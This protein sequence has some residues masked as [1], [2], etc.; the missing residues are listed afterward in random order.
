MTLCYGENLI[1]G[2]AQ[3]AKADNALM[4]FI[5]NV[6][7]KI[8]KADNDSPSIRKGISVFVQETADSKIAFYNTAS[9]KYIEEFK[10]FKDINHMALYAAMF[11]NNGY[12]Q[13]EDSETDADRV[14]VLR[15]GMHFLY[16]KYAN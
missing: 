4:R 6:Y 8:A 15:K 12:S 10:E 11:M 2:E 5:K 7:E 3:D 9:S 1:M 16:L 13:I 14:I